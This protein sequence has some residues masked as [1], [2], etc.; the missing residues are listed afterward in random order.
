M[1]TENTTG[2]ALARQPHHELTPLLLSVPQ[3]ARLLGVGTT[4]CWEMVHTGQ[5]SS[6][7]I[8]RR[9]LIPR[10]VVEQLAR[11]HAFEPMHHDHVGADDESSQAG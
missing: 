3:T 2:Q 8:G 10:T 11:I 9:V 6:V 1:V 5:L 7:R 4:L